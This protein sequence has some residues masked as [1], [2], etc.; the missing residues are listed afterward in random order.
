[1]M[2]YHD[3]E[4]VQYRPSH[5]V[6]EENRM[7]SSSHLS[8]LRI[9]Y[10]RLRNTDIHWAVTGSLNFVLQG[11][12]VEPHDIDIQTDEAGAYAIERIFREQVVRPVEYRA[13]ATMRS[14]FGVLEIADSKVEI[15]G[16]IQKHL[17]DGTWEKPINVEQYRRFVNVENILIPVLTLEYEYQA[18]LIMG[19]IEKARMLRE[20]LDS[21]SHRQEHSGDSP[22]QF[23]K[24]STK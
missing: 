16:A 18:Y 23:V 19:R 13:S 6:L 4:E 21:Q 9:I 14:H 11:I 12:P 2:L 5:I 15:M 24:Y 17:A 1:M 7:I 22:V 10:E 8:A 3:D 20:W